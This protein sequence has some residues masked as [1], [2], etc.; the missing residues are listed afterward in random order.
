[1]SETDQ[2]PPT[3]P[4]QR[5]C[6]FS[7]P[8]ELEELRGT[9]P[10]SRMRFADDSEGWLLTRH[11]DVRAALA[12]RSVSSH[13]GRT[14]QPWRN[15]A[16]EMRA[17]EYLPGFLIFMDPPNHSRYRR[18]LTKWFTM[19]A[20][21]KLEPRIEQIVSDALDAMEAEGGPVDLVQSFALPIPLLVICE[22]M[23]IRYDD[24]VE[25]MDMVLRLQDLEATPEEL[26]A[27]G[28]KMNQFMIDLCAAKRKNPGDDL[29]S[30]LIQDPDAEPALTDLEVAGI[31]V[32]MLIAGHETSANML[33]IGTY[34]LLQNPGQW[35]LLRNDI[36]LIDQAVEE[37]LR[38]QTIVQQGLPRGVTED[39]EIAGHAIK[40]GETL[41]A[42]LPAANRDPEVFPDPDRLDITREH[43]PHLAFGHGI[44]LCLGM[45][46][47]RV[48]MRCAWRGLVK[49][50]PD[51]RM[52]ARIEDIPWRDDQIVYGVYKLPV[53]WGDAP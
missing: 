10:I 41:L 45:E 14:P 13:P 50:F 17:E 38:H 3:L 25:F 6:P 4:R 26:G 21:R 18:L 16:P 47:A 42:S 48:E 27:L 40:P 7:P 52:A 9:D 11:A 28:A 46:L 22:L 44:H 19:R 8:P 43:N 23:G 30:H 33:G 34:T 31:G 35:D 53:T 36:G 2:R 37:L 5:T 39:M 12:S 20:I 32:L 24:R 15:L 49:R 29:L 1:M 51:L